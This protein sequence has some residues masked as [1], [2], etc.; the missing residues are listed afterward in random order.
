MVLAYLGAS[1]RS[2]PAAQPSTVPTSTG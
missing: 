2:R 1:R